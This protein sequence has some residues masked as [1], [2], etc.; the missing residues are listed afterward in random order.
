MARSGVFPAY[1]G[2]E[3]VYGGADIPRLRQLL[4]SEGIRSC[5]LSAFGLYKRKSLLDFK[6]LEQDLQHFD[7]VIVDSGM[8]SA[9]SSI[10]ARVTDVE[11]FRSFYSYLI[12][13]M[14]GY[15]TAFGVLDYLDGEMWTVDHVVEHT[16][17][18][19]SRFP[20]ACIMPTIFSFM[21]VD[22][23]R[24]VYDIMKA[25]MVA[26]SYSDK[27]RRRCIETVQFLSEHRMHGYGMATLTDLRFMRLY[28]ADSFVWSSGSRFG[29]TFQFRGGKLRSF[30]ARDKREVRTGLLAEAEAHG[31][32]RT[33]IEK[34]FYS[35]SGDPV[36]MAEIDRFN[37]LQWKKY[38]A[39][40]KRATTDG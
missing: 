1:N 24:A 7:L 27:Y 23:V 8:F 21:S 14:Q 3:L 2:T 10:S 6:A 36:V 35:S 30:N 38:A 34:D 12:D 28:S 5:K 16:H 22:D 9:R 40:L 15:V 11:D 29:T 31:I 13:N 19:I 18:M 25:P 32:N 26:V 20:H 17:N 37:L 4:Q 39:Y 33:V